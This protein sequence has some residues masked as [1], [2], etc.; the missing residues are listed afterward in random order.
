MSA[1]TL[2]ERVKEI[3]Q[4]FFLQPDTDGLHGIF[5]YFHQDCIL[6]GLDDSQMCVGIDAIEEALLRK[7]QEKA[8]LSFRFTDAQY[9]QRFLQDQ[10]GQ[11]FG[12]L[13]ILGDDPTSSASVRPNHL[14]DVECSFAATFLQCGDDFKMISGHLCLSLGGKFGSLHELLKQ[15][16]QVTQ[17]AN[18]DPVTS[19]YNHRAFFDSAQNTI[20]PD[21]CYLMVV[22]LDNFKQIND[23]YGHL[24]GVTVLKRTGQILRSAVREKDIVGRI[25]GDEFAVLC[26]GID[27]DDAALAV[28]QRM[29]KNVQ[30]FVG[31]DFSIDVHIS[32]GIARKKPGDSLQDTFRQA[33]T[34]LYQVKRTSKNGCRLFE[35]A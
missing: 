33:D 26:I 35:D 14:I 9:H 27:S 4:A 21:N 8:H 19:L 28:A 31:R 32:I 13:H 1:N 12:S 24:T 5:H 10:V 11:V 17:L 3:F 23:T 7:K 22:D 30:Q 2:T 15:F 25:G 29:V 20:S 34:A 16:Q 18:Q 6:C